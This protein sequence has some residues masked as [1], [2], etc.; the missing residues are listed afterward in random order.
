MLTQESCGKRTHIAHTAH[1]A[2]DIGAG[3][4]FDVANGVRE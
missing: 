1:E 4:R 3:R 2:R